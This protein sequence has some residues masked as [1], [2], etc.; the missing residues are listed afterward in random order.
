[1]KKTFK[2]IVAGLLTAVSLMSNA[3]LNQAVYAEENDNFVMAIAVD[4]DGLDPHRTTA[5]ST[6]GIT[7][8][9]YDTLVGVNSEGG[10]VPRLASEWEVSEDGKE[11]T[12][13]LSE[14]VKFHN[15]VDCNAEAVKASFERLKGDESPRAG[16]YANIV[17][18]E[19]LEDNKI[20]F[21]T[22]ELD[23]ELLSKFAYPW[24]AVVE[25]GA[26]ADLK[27]KPVG[28]GA[29]ELVE[30][31]PQESLKLTKYSEGVVEA[32]IENVTVRTIPDA[33]SR[34]LALQTGE[35]DMMYVSGD[36][37]DLVEAIDG[38]ELY[39]TEANSLQVMAMNNENEYLSNPQVRRAITMAVDKD[40]LIENVWNGLGNK[41]GSHY[42]PV[43][44]EYVDHSN[45]IEYNPE[46][47]KEILA[48]EGYADGFTL[49][50][51]LPKDYQAYVDAGQIIAQ[52]L[53][54][55]GIT[56]DIEI[57]EWAYWLESVYQGRN[58]DLTVVGHT[59]RLDAYQWL[60]RYKSDSGENY[61]NYKNDRV[62]EILTTAPQTIDDEERTKLYQ[63]LQ[64]ILAEEVPALYI[65]SP[66]QVIAL[67]DKYTGYTA[68]P[69]DINNFADLKV[70]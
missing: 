51:Y 7:N 43:L 63:E 20:K 14:G 49:K 6:F 4:P 30:W 59:G 10:I 33:Q 57:V 11:I 2:K 42:P 38:V 36:Q 61:V 50:M 12:F 44:Q 34:I 55:V 70:K 1:M 47:A 27:N 46:K 9:I 40:S 54:A 53:Q 37:L 28:T 18:I 29:Y 62:D 8:N 67:S 58:Y 21:V 13:T 68:Y 48:E 32:E 39:K 17:E 56:C 31:T 23:V 65:Q 41:I 66:I 25:V 22:E 16:D 19:V 3:T 64:A 60:A 45:D 52:Q 35:V 5:A 24:A 26:E 69:I 15:G